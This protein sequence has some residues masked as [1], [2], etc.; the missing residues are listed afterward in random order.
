MKDTEFFNQSNNELFAALEKYPANTKEHRD[1]V[2]KIVENNVGLVLHVAKRFYPIMGRTLER[3]DIQSEGYYGLLK[4]VEAFNLGKGVSFH[5]YAVPCI[6]NEI[7]QRLIREQRHRRMPSLQ[8]NVAIDKNGARQKREDVLAAPIDLEAEIVEQDEQRQQLV[9][10]RSSLD[11]LPPIQKK[12]LTAKY[13]SG[14]RE[15][16]ILSDT[17]IAKQF[18][19]SRQAVS[20]ASKCALANLKAMYCQSFPQAPAEAAA[21]E[22]TPAAKSAL[23]GKLKEL[24]LTKLPPRR[25]A[26]MLCK[27]YSP[28]TKTNQ[29]V[30]Q[31]VNIEPRAVANYVSAACAKLYTLCN[32]IQ[33]RNHLRTILEFRPA[34][35]EKELN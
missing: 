23:K 12:F 33:D 13:F 35:N 4:A 29:Q 26:V 1:L 2:A 24:I 14:D 10:L 30:T 31:E 22:L 18:G 19:C 6:E 21:T 5:N 16:K 3:D 9:W 32:S 28:T 11:Q 7:K 34:E 8:D 25:Q 17:D 20:V 15:E 27:Y